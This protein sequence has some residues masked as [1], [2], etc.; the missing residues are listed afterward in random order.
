MKFLT[1]ALSLIFCIRDERLKEITLFNFIKVNG[2]YDML[3]EASEAMPFLNFDINKE[4][5]LRNFLGKEKY[6]SLVKK[7]AA[8]NEKHDPIMSI[9]LLDK[10]KLCK[11]V[12]EKLINLQFERINLF[13]PLD[14]TQPGAKFTNSNVE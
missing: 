7:A 6:T 4:L 9:C 11:E 13:K 1:E 8:L 5:S 14:F 3:L 12:L 10:I 2:L